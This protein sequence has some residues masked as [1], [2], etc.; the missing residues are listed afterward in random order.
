MMAGKKV[1]F[2]TAMSRLQE[3]VKKLESGEESLEES[4]KLFEEG[5]KLSAKC[6]EILEKAEQRVS[7][8]KTVSGGEDPQLEEEEEDG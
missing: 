6:Y 1:D 3:I 8:L 4:M 2:E 5:A 7:Q